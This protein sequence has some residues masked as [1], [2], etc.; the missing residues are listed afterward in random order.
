MKLQCYLSVV[1]TSRNDDHGG[2]LLQRMQIF[3]NSL[4]TQIRNFSLSAELIIVEWNP[5]ENRPRL[6]R[7]LQWPKG[8]RVRIIEVPSAI[9]RRFNLSDKLP[10]F[11]MIAKN[12]GIDIKHVEM[13][14][15]RVG[16]TGPRGGQITIEF[17]SRYHNFMIELKKVKGQFADGKHRRRKW[18]QSTFFL[19]D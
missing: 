6:S 8:M 15:V 17:L 13:G 11:Q 10:L 12:V 19:G 16:V 14:N 9:H 4:A 3:I 7:V 5:P 1:V 2:N 18:L